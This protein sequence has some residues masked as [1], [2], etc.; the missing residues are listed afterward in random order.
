[1]NYPQ[2]MVDLL[3]AINVFF[4]SCLITGPN[5]DEEKHRFS[6]YVKQYERKCPDVIS[7]LP[8][9][10]HSADSSQH[11]KAGVQDTPQNILQPRTI[12][13]TVG[14]GE[15]GQ[16][17]P[18]KPSNKLSLDMGDLDIPWSDLVLKERIGAGNLHISSSLNENP[19]A[20]PIVI[21]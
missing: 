1:M 2:I 18:S 16:L 17:I 14:H 3:S 5:T 12:D 4:L 9:P 11:G 21:Q 15:G 10:V 8:T 6:M 19:L 13:P 20:K 7:I